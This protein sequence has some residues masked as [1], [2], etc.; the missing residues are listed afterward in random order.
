MAGGKETPRQKMIG[1]MY[2]VLTAL[3]ALQ[4]SS[5]IIDKFVILNE[6]IEYAVKESVVRNKTTVDNIKKAVVE[7]GNKPIELEVV[8]QAETVRKESDALISFMAKLKD[9][10]IAKSGGREEDGKSFKGAKEEDAVAVY[11][12][13][14]GETKNGEAYKLQKMLNDYA[15]NM[16]KIM[17][18]K[19][20]GKLAMDGKEDPLFKDNPEQKNKDFAKLNF[21]STPMVAAL[22]VLSELQSKVTNIEAS[23]MGDLKA[24]VGAA[25]FKFD[26]VLPMVKPESRIV[27]AGTK[28][29]AEMFVGARD[30]KM[31][32]TMSYGGKKLDVKNG[33]GI[34]EFTAQGGNYD[35]EGNFKTK[36]KG[37]I[38]IPKPTGGDTT[39]NIEEEY[40]VARPV[41]QIQS[42]SV[43]ALYF[44][45]G[46]KLNVMVPALGATYNP[47]FT[48]TGADFLTS[49]K[50]GEVTIVPNGQQ[51]KLVVSSDGN[52]IGDQ[53]F[54]V[55]PIPKPEIVALANGKPVDE[56]AGMAAP[57][58]RSIT[59][60]AKPDEGFKTFLPD[61]ARYQ[62]TAYVVTLARGRRVIATKNATNQQV[63]LVEF[64]SQASAN[65]RIII[66]IKSVKRK[67]FRDQVE[68]VPGMANTIKIISLN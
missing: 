26:V 49:G 11:M 52:L 68:E 3:L 58:P 4:V 23:L 14:A 59:M 53:M 36:W 44:N 41:I 50:K 43:S 40:I 17:P 62:V 35:A 63:D 46:N 21:E 25:D 16:T 10:L 47:K 18:D 19:K 7:R 15:S 20:F 51:V 64:A 38:T 54:K 56:K 60:V 67:N 61:D 31:I 27:A 57:G 65:D 42:A 34:V 2:L 32:P 33:I 24:K 6:S 55:R 45:C 9:D 66:D 29:K 30:S 8:K 28:Y 12:V 5:A 39:L 48:G 22:A 37:Q 13:G 1:M